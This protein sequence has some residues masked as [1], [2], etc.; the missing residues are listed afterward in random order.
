MRPILL[1]TLAAAGLA[2]AGCES[3]PVA[4]PLPKACHVQPDA[5]KQQASMTGF[6]F[7]R[8]SQSC[9]SIAYG[10]DGSA[11]FQTLGACMSACYAPAPN[12]TPDSNG[13]PHDSK[14]K[15]Q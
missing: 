14:P 10:K 12:L 4:H 2:L 8:D 13:R 1:L 7:D 3:T 9:K 15:I 6:Y 11:P 5:G